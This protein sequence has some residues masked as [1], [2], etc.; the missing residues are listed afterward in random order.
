MDD[1]S[2]FTWIFPLKLKS[3]VKETFIHFQKLVERKFDSKI[4]TLQSDWGGEYRSLAPFLTSA[5][6]HF[7]HPCPHTHPQNGK[8][9]RKHRHI[10]EMGLTLLTQAKM[11]LHFWW[12][13]FSTFT[14]LINHLS[15]PTLNH[16]SPINILLHVKPNLNFLK[17][18]GYACFPHLR[19]YNQH[20]LDFRSTKY[21]FIGYSPNHKG[22]LCLHPLG[23]VY[24]SQSVTFNESDFPFAAGFP[25][26]TFLN[27][28][29]T[30]FIINY[31]H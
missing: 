25:N 21:V 23:R 6:I 1:F 3:E 4:K 22:Y 24:N 15:T 17:V 31:N 28:Q 14:F 7:R 18:F 26:H 29:T 8:S 27:S 5:G 20:K 30:H 10:I 13:A 12:E 2:N 19:D 11:P 16:K 9:E